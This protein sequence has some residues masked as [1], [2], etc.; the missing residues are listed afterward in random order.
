VWCIGERRNTRFW[1][2]IYGKYLNYMDSNGVV[3]IEWW[4]GTDFWGK[5]CSGLIELFAWWNWRKHWKIS[6][7][8]ASSPAEL[9]IQHPR[10]WESTALPQDQR[11]NI[12]VDLRKLV[13][14]RLDSSQEA[15]RFLNIA[16]HSGIL[17]CLVLL[18]TC[19]WK[20]K[21]KTGLLM[22]FA[23]S[24][25]AVIN[26]WNFIRGSLRFSQHLQFSSQL[27]VVLRCVTLQVGTTAL[28]EPAASIFSVQEFKEF[29]EASQ[30]FNFLR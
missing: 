9:R 13:H 4:I 1:S 21:H 16:I 24:Q 7:R 12:N 11:Q 20:P 28:Q 19:P 15:Q 14:E 3:V 5:K 10:A 27:S 8:I 23:Q 22:F 25:Q 30:P 2:E 18:S 26:L 6:V 29:C 17:A